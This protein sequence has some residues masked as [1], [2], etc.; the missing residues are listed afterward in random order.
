MGSIIEPDGTGGSGADAPVHLRYAEL[1]P[2]RSLKRSEEVAR[3]IVRDI[4]DRQL[5]PG[6]LVSSE[7]AML[8]TYQVS[9][10][11]LREALRLLETQ[12][13][14]EL[15][16]G[17]GGG[18][19][20]GT[21]DAS[22]LGRL[23]TLYFQLEGGTYDDLLEAWVFA[24]SSL[25]EAAACNPDLKARRAAMD[26]F[27]MKLFEGAEGRPEPVLAG[28]AFHRAVADLAAN[29]VLRLLLASVRTI[30]APH[31]IDHLGMKVIPHDSSEEHV[32]IARSIRAGHATRAKQLAGD[33][34]RRLVDACRI[35]IGDRV[36]EPIDWL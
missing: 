12:G 7:T 17:R 19:H 35:E 9:R 11:S 30:V 16:R 3:Q 24:E 33:H 36:R 22:S 29:P 4:I 31:L 23:T 5:P 8:V 14:V 6:A 25:A 10:E 1:L 20:V 34:T 28:L 15:R 26:A 18:A 27:T 2:R 21:V 13:L 32:A